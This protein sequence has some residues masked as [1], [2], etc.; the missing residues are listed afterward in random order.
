VLDA[1]RADQAAEEAEV[2]G[3][4]R[5]LTVD[6]TLA[7]AQLDT[8]AATLAS[9]RER[10]APAAQRALDAVAAAYGVGQDT[11]LDW[12]DA[13]RAI[14]ELALEEAELLGEVGHAL[15]DLTSATGALP[16]EF[17]ADRRSTRTDHE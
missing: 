14:R 1:A 15:A 10:E 4:E 16:T 6:V 17:E 8:L 3:L 7:L 2:R 5:S 13:A 12:L 11:L 9:L